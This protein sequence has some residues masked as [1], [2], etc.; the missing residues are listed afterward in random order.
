MITRIFDKNKFQ[1]SKIISKYGKEHFNRYTYNENRFFSTLNQKVRENITLNI[2]EN[3][4]LLALK[5][6]INK[7][8][9]TK[10]YVFYRGLSKNS[11]SV[12]NDFIELNKIKLMKGII[13]TS[14][15]YSV[16]KQYS[17]KEKYQVILKINVPVNYNCFPVLNN[18]KHI[19]EHE[20]LF[21]NLKY[22]VINY[23]LKENKLFAEID[24][25]A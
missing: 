1:I 2:E 24:V 10:K 7:C 5:L 14:L 17:E 9:T 20:I 11:S 12:F 22:K 6:A 25:L 16:A 18:S 15:D 4:T 3:K 23:L 8:K 21:Y 19:E 13:S